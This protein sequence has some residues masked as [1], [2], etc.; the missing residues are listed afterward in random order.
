MDLADKFGLSHVRAECTF[1]TSAHVTFSKIDYVI[2]HKTI[3]RKFLK[4]GIIPS[5]FSYHNVVKLEVDNRKK[6]GKCTNIWKLNNT[7]LNNQ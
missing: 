1:F 5:I 7:L 6:A 3:P 4:I 2:G